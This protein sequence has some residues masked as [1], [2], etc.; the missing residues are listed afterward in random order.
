MKYKIFYRVF[1]I[2]I[3]LVSVLLNF[4]FVLLNESLQFCFRNLET[5]QSE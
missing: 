3:K 5:G 2:L 4:S 1:C